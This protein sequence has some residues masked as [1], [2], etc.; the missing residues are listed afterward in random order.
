MA[1][2]TRTGVTTFV[3]QRTVDTGNIV[4]Q[5]ATDIG[6]E[7]NTGQLAAR[8]SMRGA[9]LVGE[10]LD[11]IASGTMKLQAQDDAL[12]SPAPKIKPDDRAINFDGLAHDVINRVRALAP[13]PA[14]IARFRGKSV[15]LLALRDSGDLSP[16]FSSAVGGEVIVAN[17][18]DSLAVAIGGRSVEICSIQPEGKRV[19][20][21]TDF[22]RGYRAQIGDRFE[23]LSA[24]GH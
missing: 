15:K 21:G 23:T 1:G 20:S 14:A 12:A 11:M 17:P 13:K 24:L 8:L 2:E 3:L 4:A 22:V 10:T 19:Q 5:A 9:Q 18:R 7:E 6:A 16:Q